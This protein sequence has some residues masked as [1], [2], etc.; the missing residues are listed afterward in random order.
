MIQ[1]M[2]GYGAA[3]RAEAGVVYALELKSV[4][5]RYL[6]ISLKLPD[7]WQFAE[8]AL[9]KRLRERLS[10]GSVVCALRIKQDAAG[11]AATINLAAMQSYLDQL[12]QV[13]LPSGVTATIDLATLACLP[14]CTHSPQI[15]DE[16]RETEFAIVESVLDRA[17]D[18]LIAM[19]REEG[20]AL[21]E[22]LRR[23]ADEVRARIIAIDA[24]A[25]CVVDEYHE[26]LRA[27]VTTLLHKGEFELQA[28]GLMREVAIYAERCDVSEELTRLKS[29]LDQFRQLCERDEPVG[30]TLEFLTQ[31]L[32]REA[33]TIASKSNHA[34]IARNV[35]D[36]KGLIDRLKEQVQNVE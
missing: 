34:G 28:E 27:R 16:T 4:N 29:H 20:G 30:R 23:I 10:R 5:H 11:S 2:T 25:P 22:E 36:I 12:A 15:E 35:V 8:A 3:E 33:N 32:L 13:G 6:K 7:D 17:L 24:W 26:R 31:E 1:S 9:E 21:Q 19:R 14:G 18:A